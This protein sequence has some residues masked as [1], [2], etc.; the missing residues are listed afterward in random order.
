MHAPGRSDISS[1]SDKQKAFCREQAL[2]YMDIA[3]HKQ[4]GP[5]SFETMGRFVSVGT[6][7]NDPLL[8]SFFTKGEER[9]FA[10]F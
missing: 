3:F 7:Q 2:P 8:R 1:G 6:R 5:W 4:S 9:N 10:D